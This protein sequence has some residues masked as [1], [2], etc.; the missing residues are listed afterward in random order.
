[1]ALDDREEISERDVVA[2]LE[3]LKRRELPARS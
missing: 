2:A 3:D 1:M